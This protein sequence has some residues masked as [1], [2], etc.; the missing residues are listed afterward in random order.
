MV[1]ELLPEL[2]RHDVETGIYV[3]VV[4][5]DG[6]NVVKREA[7]IDGFQCLQDVVEC[8]PDLPLKIGFDVAF[9]IPAALTGGANCVADFDGLRIVIL[10]SVGLGAGI[11]EELSGRHVWRYVRWIEEIE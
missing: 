3:Q 2:R 8:Q 5:A 6:I 11:V 1:G 7:R 10:L 9:L 4:G